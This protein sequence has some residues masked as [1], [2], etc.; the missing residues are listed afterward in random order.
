MISHCWNW[1]KVYFSI[2][3]KNTDLILSSHQKEGFQ[4]DWM[5]SCA[6]YCFHFLNYNFP[7]FDLNLSLNTKERSESFKRERCDF[8]AVFLIVPAFPRHPWRTG[9]GEE[10]AW[11]S[12][13]SHTPLL[14]R[15]GLCLIFYH[16]KATIS[17]EESIKFKTICPSRLLPKS[18]NPSEAKFPRLASGRLL[19][20]LQL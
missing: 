11:H 10:S 5:S 8:S 16:P 19:S 14:S 1:R 6:F 4:P 20:H 2:W 17:S 13:G 18:Q 15:P 7:N 9:A 12:G 3:M